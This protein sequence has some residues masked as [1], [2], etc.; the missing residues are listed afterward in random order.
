MLV[1]LVY[2]D[3]ATQASPP[4]FTR[5]VKGAVLCNYHHVNG[6]TVITGLLC[7]QTKIEAVTGVVLYNEQ[8][9]RSSCLG[10]NAFFVNYQLILI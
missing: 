4:S 7:S 6:D 8:D 2:E 5:L 3:G 1:Y 10:S 9:S